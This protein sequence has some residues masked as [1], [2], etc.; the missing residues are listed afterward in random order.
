MAASG[1][2][3]VGDAVATGHACESVTTI[4]GP[5]LPTVLIEG[6]VAARVGDMLTPHTTGV[7]PFC[8]S[9]TMPIIGPGNP[10]VLV[11]GLPL[12]TIGTPADSGAITSGATTV[13]A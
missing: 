11:G 9:H 13:L 7:P 4:A 12:A 1:A 6:K 3:R 10:T 2:A 8:V 5:G